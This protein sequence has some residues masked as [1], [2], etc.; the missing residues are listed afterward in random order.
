MG[1]QAGIKRPEEAEGLRQ[2]GA[3]FWPMPFTLIHTETHIQR[4]RH[5]DIQ[6]HSRWV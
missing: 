3:S 1:Q 6:A 2:R 5:K 4:Q